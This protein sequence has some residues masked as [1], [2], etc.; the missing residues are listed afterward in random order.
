MR[1]HEIEQVP[2]QDFPK[3]IVEKYLEWASPIGNL[4]EFTINYLEQG[5]QRVLILTDLD[6]NVSAYA[7]FVSRLN[8]RVWQAKNAQSYSPHTGRALAAKIY[9][10]VK[11]KLRKS[12]QSDTEQSVSAIKLWTKTLPGLGLQP[13]VFDTKTDRIISPDGFDLALMYP[14]ADTE[15]KLRYTWILER[16]DHYPMQNLL[17]EDSLLLPVTGMWYNPNKGKL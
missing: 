15:D 2:A 1:L 9:K 4:E 8:G 11:E 10:V 13:M 17:K 5:D 3:E 14:V 6:T 16:N 12:I 7:G